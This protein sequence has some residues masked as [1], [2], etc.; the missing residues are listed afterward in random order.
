MRIIHWFLRNFNSV[1]S[2]MVTSDPSKVNFTKVNFTTL[3]LA[4]LQ[5]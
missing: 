5:A 4:K 3:I 1:S 2:K